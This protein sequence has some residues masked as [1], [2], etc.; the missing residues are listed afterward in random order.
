MVVEV[1][2]MS[3]A[4]NAYTIRLYE[5]P[6]GGDLEKFN[7]LSNKSDEE[8]KE[9]NTTSKYVLTITKEQIAAKKAGKLENKMGFYANT[10][11]NKTLKAAWQVADMSH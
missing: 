5:T 8:K 4:T 3:D 1:E 2:A 6:A 9:L 11:T 7:M 10:Y